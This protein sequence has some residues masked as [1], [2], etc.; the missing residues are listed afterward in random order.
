MVETLCELYGERIIVPYSNGFRTFYDF[1]DS[2]RMLDDPTLETVLRTRGFGYRALS[3]VQASK[4][5]VSSYL[6]IRILSDSGI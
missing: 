5:L 1:A 2:K 3:I 6:L 4:A